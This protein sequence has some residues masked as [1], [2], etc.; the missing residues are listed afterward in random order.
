[1]RQT[2]NYLVAPMIAVLLFWGC[3]PKS[4]PQESQLDIPAWSAFSPSQYYYSLPCCI[5][6]PSR[7]NY[8]PLNLESSMPCIPKTPSG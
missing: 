5:E 2:I 6:F 1:M 3:T 8:Y 4:Q 7:K